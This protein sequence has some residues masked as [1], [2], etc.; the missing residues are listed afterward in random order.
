[1]A[2]TNKD[3]VTYDV[4]TQMLQKLKERFVEKGEMPDMTLERILDSTGK[5]SAEYLPSYV[6]DVKEYETFAK[7]PNPGEQDKLYVDDSTEY[8]YRWSG[9]RYVNITQVAKEATKLEKPILVNGVKMDGS[10]DVN[11]P[12]YDGNFATVAETDKEITD[13]VNEAVEEAET[14][15]AS[16]MSKQD[17]EDLCS[18][19]IGTFSGGG[20]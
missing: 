10:Q 19:T 12:V 16:C 9:T 17:A 15:K 8:V 4:L 11:I 3:I 7:F 20:K 1:M 18:A 5:I 6:D 13:A 2:E 14:V